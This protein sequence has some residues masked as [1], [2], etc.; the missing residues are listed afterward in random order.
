MPASWLRLG[1]GSGASWL[2]GRS[3]FFL[4]FFTSVLP[5][6]LANDLDDAH[7]FEVHQHRA[8]AVFER[9]IHIGDLLF[10]LLKALERAHV[11]F[12]AQLLK[13]SHNRARGDAAAAL[14][15]FGL[16]LVCHVASLSALTAL[17]E[18]GRSLP[19]LPAAFR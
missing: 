8:H 13:L 10:G 1:V 11:F 16:A 14:A 9:R 17:G 18:P 3:M 5:S 12:C 7:A 15:A 6:L 4:F 19:G 2:L